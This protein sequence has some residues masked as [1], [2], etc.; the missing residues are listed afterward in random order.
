MEKHIHREIEIKIMAFCHLLRF[1]GSSRKVSNF[2]PIKILI[3]PST[4]LEGHQSE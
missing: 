2:K 4:H 1:K 3:I